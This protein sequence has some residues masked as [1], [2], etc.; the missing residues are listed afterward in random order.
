MNSLQ[1]ALAGVTR[2]GIDTSPFIYLLETHPLYFPLVDPLFKR[3]DEGEF[4]AATSTITLAEVTVLPLRL[5]RYDLQQRYLDML[6]NG[7]NLTIVPID[8]QVAQTAAELR[9]QYSVHLPDALQLA[10]AILAK[11]DTFVTNDRTLKQVTDIPVLVLN[12]LLGR[13]E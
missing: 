7:T 3:L 4:S 11:C 1:E 2:I 13:N 10:A 6:L 9:A 8:I 5:R 12:D